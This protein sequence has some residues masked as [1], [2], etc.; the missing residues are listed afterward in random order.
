[1]IEV[2]LKLHYVHVKDLVTEV[3]RQTTK[4]CVNK[5]FI[6]RTLLRHSMFNEPIYYCHITTTY[7][8]A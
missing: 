7:D 5:T 6:K 1:M 8:S 3:Q 2:A 4:Q